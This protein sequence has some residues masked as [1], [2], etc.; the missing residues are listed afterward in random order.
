M[1]S[2]ATPVDCNVTGLSISNCPS[3]YVPGSTLMSAPSVSAISMASWMLPLLMLS[4]HPTPTAVLSPLKLPAATRSAYKSTAEPLIVKFPPEFISPL[5]VTAPSAS[6][7]MEPDPNVVSF[8]TV[9]GADPA[10]PPSVPEV[11]EISPLP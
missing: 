9:T 11:I 10:S 6:R 5:T 8:P 4:N 1:V 7:A 2:A 3:S